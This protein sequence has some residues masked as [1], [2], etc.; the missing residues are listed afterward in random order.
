VYQPRIS[1]IVPVAKGRDTSKLRA[2]IDKLDYDQDLIELIFVHGNHPTKQRNEAV[3]EATGELI[4]FL[5]NDS[6][7][8]RGNIKK[9]LPHFKQKRVVAVSGPA[10]PKENAN[11]LQRG[12]DGVFSS[13]FGTGNARARHS[14]QSGPRH[15]NANMVI[16]CNFLIRKDVFENLGM[17]NEK[18]FPSEEND[19]AV[20][21]IHNAY[22]IVYEPN[23]FVTREHRSNITDLSSQ[24]FR[25]GRGRIDFFFLRPSLNSILFLIPLLFLLYLPIPFILSVQAPDFMNSVF[26]LPWIPLIAY[27]FCSLGF[28]MFNVIKTQDFAGSMMLIFLYPYIHLFYAL[29]LLFGVFKNVFF[30]RGYIV[31]GYY[32]SVEFIKKFKKLKA[33]NE[34]EGENTKESKNVKGSSNIDDY[35]F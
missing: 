11:T 14:R 2:A 34:E 27:I 35:F 28:T 21:I 13:I 20:K 5:D 6:E 30:K 22:L 17:F 3:M 18:L 33:E 16:L 8:D 1:I 29:G 31:K 12:V 19:L 24:V 4:Y 9:A 10:L 26:P 25:D 32:S 7:P 15:A 23:F